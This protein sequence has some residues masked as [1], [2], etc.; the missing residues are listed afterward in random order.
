MNTLARVRGF[1]T[2]RSA[3]HEVSFARQVADWVVFLA[4]GKV[5]ESA[6]AQAFFE[7]P[8]SEH[9]RDYLRSLMRYR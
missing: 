2:R 7:A 3:T 4:E 8:Q 9:A 5:E 6:P 1:L